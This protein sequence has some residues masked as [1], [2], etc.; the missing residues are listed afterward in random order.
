M[1]IARMATRPAR[2]APEPDRDVEESDSAANKQAAARVARRGFPVEGA[3]LTEN[4]V[5]A[6]ERKR[7]RK[8]KLKEQQPQQDKAP[9]VSLNVNA[10]DAEKDDPD[11]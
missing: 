6:S 5:Q 3:Q 1:M 10:R 4:E 7:E 8:K 11:N 2:V 9:V